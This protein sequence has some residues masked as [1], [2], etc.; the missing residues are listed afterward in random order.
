MLSYLA[1]LDFI[2]KLNVNETQLWNML[3]SIAISCGSLGLSF[4]SRD[5]KSSRILDLPGKVGWGPVMVALVTVRAM[6]VASRLAAFNIIHVSYRSRGAIGHLGGPAA[7]LAMCLAAKLSFPMAE[8]PDVLPDTFMAAWLVTTAA[9]LLGLKSL[10]LYG[11]HFVEQPIFADLGLRHL[12]GRCFEDHGDGA[13][14]LLQVLARCQALEELNLSFCKQ[15]L[16]PAWTKVC[17]AQW[18]K[19]N[20]AYFYGCFEHHGDGAEDLLQ[21]LARCQLQELI[22]GRC[23]QI[24]GPAWAN[25]RGWAQLRGASWTLKIAD[26]NQCFW[27][28]GDGAEDLLQVLARSQSLE[29]LNFK[30]CNR[31]PGTAWAKLR[32]AQWPKLRKATF[33]WCFEDHGDGAEDLLQVLARSQTL[34]EL[35]FRNCGRV[36]ARTWQQLPDGCWPKLNECNGIPAD[37]L[38]RLR[39]QGS[40]RA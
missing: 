24:A 33:Q 38:Q 12:L 19:M 10:A 9:A 32:G 25:V 15:I 39:G 17:S 3:I 27:D 30:E 7:A 18:P 21:V 6:E 4:A 22:L 34:E 23:K 11:Q 29:V 26:F 36:P 13:E 35:D 2:S 16:G 28:H 8:I 20:M 5:K 31:I 40:W 37:L 14:D 1:G